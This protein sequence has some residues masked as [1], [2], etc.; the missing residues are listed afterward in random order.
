RIIYS[1]PS[2]LNITDIKITLDGTEFTP[3]DTTLTAGDED[4]YSVARGGNTTVVVRGLCLG[5]VPK[6]GRCS[7]GDICWK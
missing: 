4:S 5:E 3:V 2:T 6:E 1:N 7:S